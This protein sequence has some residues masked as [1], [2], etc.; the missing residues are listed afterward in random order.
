MFYVFKF[1]FTV[2][3]VFFNESY[4]EVGYKMLIFKSNIM[5]L[6]FLSFTTPIKFVLYPSYRNNKENFMKYFKECLKMEKL[7]R[8]LL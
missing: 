1:V 2:Y 6:G 5:I 3:R 4:T 8:M 7:S